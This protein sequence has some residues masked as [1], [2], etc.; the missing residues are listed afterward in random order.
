MGKEGRRDFLAVSTPINVALATED[1]FISQLQ[2]CSFCPAWH[3][4][5]RSDYQLCGG[6]FELLDSSL[7]FPQP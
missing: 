2:L 1:S 3:P 7:L 6:P 4:I 5:Q